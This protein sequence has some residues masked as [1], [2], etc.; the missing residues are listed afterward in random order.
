MLKR[1]PCLKHCR[2]LLKIWKKIWLITA[3]LNFNFWYF[4]LIFKA[5]QG[6]KSRFSCSKWTFCHMLEHSKLFSSPFSPAQHNCWERGVFQHV[7]HL[8]GTGI[9][10]FLKINEGDYKNWGKGNHLWTCSNC[11]NFFLIFNCC[12]IAS[13][14]NFETFATLPIAVS[15]SC[16]NFAMGFDFLKRR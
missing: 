9:Y 7:A 12:K 3:H 10:F 16:H 2:M 4:K 15:A 8:L 6:Q 14:A 13:F 1:N 5:I 11:M